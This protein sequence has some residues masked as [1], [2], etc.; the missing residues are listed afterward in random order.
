MNARLR[1]RNLTRWC[2]VALLGLTACTPSKPDTLSSVE[3]LAALLHGAGA[4]VTEMATLAP[5]TFQVGSGQTLQVNG[6]LLHVYPYG[7]EEEARAVAEQIQTSSVELPWPGRVSAWQAGRL[8]V[9]YPGTDGGVLL[10][11]TGLLGDPLTPSPEG[12]AE[13]YPPAVAAAIAA[14]A[15]AQ[16]LDPARIEVVSYLPAEWM[17]GCLGLPAAGESC[18]PGK[19][20]GWVVGL[21]AGDLSGQA[22]TDA[23]GTQVRLAP[24][25]S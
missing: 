12:P 18:A 8:L 4:T 16:G 19:V 7:N 6:Q 21:R 22:H 15:E 10:L 20:S 17:N 11:L 24:I 9:F 5:S 1:R 3:D 23:L 13:P 14:W 2:L 25:G